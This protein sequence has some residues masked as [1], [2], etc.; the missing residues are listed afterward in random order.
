[1]VSADKVL[2]PWLMMLTLD[3]TYCRVCFQSGRRDGFGLIAGADLWRGTQAR[4]TLAG[5]R[6]RQ[7]T[8]LRRHLTTAHPEWLDRVRWAEPRPLVRPITHSGTNMNKVAMQTANADA[9]TCSECQH[10]LDAHQQVNDHTDC[11][12]IYT[13]PVT[14]EITFCTCSRGC[15]LPERC[16]GR[17][18]EHECCI[19]NTW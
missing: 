6:T 15:C 14:A 10:S 16:P 5:V 13:D 18:D 4:K 9:G 7:R 2:I 17:S 12:S 11:T 3:H 19:C 8:A 1:M